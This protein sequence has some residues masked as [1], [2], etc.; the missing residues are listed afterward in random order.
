[1][2]ASAWV[3]GGGGEYNPVTPE[4]AGKLAEIVGEKFVVFGDAEKL[5][6]SSHDEIT[7]PQ[8]AHV[9]EV[10][11]RARSAEEISA[12]LRLAEMTGRQRRFELR[13]PGAIYSSSHLTNLLEDVV[14]DLPLESEAVGLH[15]RPWQVATVRVEC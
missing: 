1:M 9:P 4:Q 2:G 3:M 7:H 10:V 13:L 12:V 15:L 14:A 5:A 8:R 6:A 11:V